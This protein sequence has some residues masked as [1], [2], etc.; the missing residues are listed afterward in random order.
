M[1]SRA[2][3]GCLQPR[4][5]VGHLTPGER[6]VAELAAGGKTN[7]EIAQALFVTVKAVQYHLTNVYRKLGVGDRAAISGALASGRAGER[8]SGQ[9]A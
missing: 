2:A 1:Q 3:P 9:E 7:R 8:A 4:E 5:P 6:R